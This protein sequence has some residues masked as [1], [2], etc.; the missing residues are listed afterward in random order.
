MHSFTLPKP[1][2][3]VVATACAL[4]FIAP[5]PG[6]SSFAVETAGQLVLYL[7]IQAESIA[8]LAESLQA[9]AA[10]NGPAGFT[11]KTSDHWHAFQQGL[12]NGRFGAYFAPPH[13]AA[14]AIARHGFKPL[15]RL[16]EPL[17]YVIAAKRADS[18]LFEISDLANRTI[19]SNKP[20]NLD[21]LLINQAFSQSLVSAKLK[22]V[23]SVEKQMLNPASRC[24]AFSLSNHLFEKHARL[25]PGKFI[26]LQQSVV[27]N[28]Y[29]LLVH[30]QVPADLAGK[31]Q[32]Y[33][34]A[35]Q[36]QE[37]LSPM[38]IML[39][40]K[41]Q[42]VRS[43]ADDYPAEYWRVLMPYWGTESE[44]RKAATQQ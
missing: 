15:L 28:N 6:R 20:L 32:D 18:E 30:P 42:L 21:Y 9:Q 12:R 31:L 11:I 16:A 3:V 43:E 29:V 36:T 38:F 8:N 33:F 24:D 10:S 22:F 17:S 19:C 27:Y 7:P 23:A 2:G 25:S 39:A 4:L 44:L 26:R 1:I 34:L 40:S 37:L 14:W 13:F 5:D 35:R 41:G